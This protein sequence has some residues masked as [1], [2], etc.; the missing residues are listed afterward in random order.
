M[1]VTVREPGR[2]YA[3][4]Y[5]DRDRIVVDLRFEA[6]EPPVPLRSGQPPYPA[7]THYDQTGR[8]T[9]VVQLDGERIDVDCWAMRDR[10][11]GPRPERGY[12]R[13]GYTWAAHPTLSWVAY[14]A[15]G[16]DAADHV[17][18]GYLR[19]GEELAQLTGGR[20]TVTRDARH[21]WVTAIDVELTDGAGR[22]VHAHAEALSRL[23]LPGAT[24][25]CVNSVLRWD[26]DGQVLYGEDQDVWPLAE[27]RRARRAAVPGVGPCG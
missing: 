17:H 13:V 12:H 14:T 2:V 21:G 27:W 8:V 6:L 20:R 1:T 9:G 22:V 19:R 26:V 4:G 24:S 18:A 5:D 15:P 23:V 11:W 25:L 3:L 16:D 10:S 7:A